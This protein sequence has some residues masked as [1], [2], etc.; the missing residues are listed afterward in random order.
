MTRK[1][2]AVTWVSFCIVLAMVAGLA[3]LAIHYLERASLRLLPKG[4]QK[5][6]ISHTLVRTGQPTWA[7]H[8]CEH[9]LACA[10]PPASRAPVRR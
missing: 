1:H 4:L 5:R 8:C 6:Q 10:G 3:W 7:L 2:T 9:G